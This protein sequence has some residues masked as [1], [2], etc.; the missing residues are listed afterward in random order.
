M[1][2]EY[3]RYRISRDRQ[4]GFPHAYYQ[5]SKAL[6]DPEHCLGHELS[7]CEEE[8]DRFILRIQR[9]LLCPR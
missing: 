4:D 6:D 9:S 1:V 5:A 2:V 7:Q 3:I 8:P